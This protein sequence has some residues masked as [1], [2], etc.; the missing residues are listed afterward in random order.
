MVEKTTDLSQVTDKRYHIMLY[1]SPWSRFELTTSVVIGTDCIGSCKSSYH[2]IMTT[3]V[4]RV[5]RCRREEISERT[6]W[7]YLGWN[8]QVILHMDLTK[9]IS[10]YLYN[11]LDQDFSFKMVDAD[12]WTKYNARKNIL[13]KNF[14]F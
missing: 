9:F 5:G 10:L 2:M 12:S 4:P 1:T 14:K 6:V 8:C 11:C 7:I 3:T 13:N